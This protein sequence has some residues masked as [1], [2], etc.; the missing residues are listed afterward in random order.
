VRLE[1]GLKPSQANIFKAIKESAK[2]FLEKTAN[3]H[4]KGTLENENIIICMTNSVVN[5]NN[6][7]VS[8]IDALKVIL[9]KVNCRLVV[10]GYNLPGTRET[11]MLAGLCESTMEGGFIE[12]PG[13]EEI[14]QLFSSI[15]NYRFEKNR[16]LI[17]ETFN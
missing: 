16:P 6:T 9:K 12:N 11:Q 14:D 8:E 17:M 3:T 5:S 7:S 15:A 13:Q 10:F 4:K 2:E 1:D